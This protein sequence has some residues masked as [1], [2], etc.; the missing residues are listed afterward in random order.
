LLDK[1]LANL[2]QECSKNFIAKQSITETQKHTTN[3]NILEVG[4]PPS[5]G[6]CRVLIYATGAV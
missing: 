6:S 3:I 2:T 4:R 1:L 5:R